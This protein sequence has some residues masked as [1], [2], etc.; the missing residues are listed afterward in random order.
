M[1]IRKAFKKFT[2]SL[3]T[4]EK[5]RANLQLFFNLVFLVPEA[6]SSGAYTNFPS[7]ITAK[8]IFSYKPSILTSETNANTVEGIIPSCIKRCL[9]STKNLFSKA[10]L[11]EMWPFCYLRTGSLKNYVTVGF[12]FVCFCREHSVIDDATWHAFKMSTA[13]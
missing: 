4:N 7:K 13:K 1:S 12:K 6:R 11:T 3:S 9:T 10:K 8:Q 5:S 2:Q